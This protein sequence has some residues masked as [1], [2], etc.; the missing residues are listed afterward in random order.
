MSLWRSLLP[1]VC[2][3]HG[4]AVA[5]G[6]DIALCAD[7]VVMAEDARI[8]HPPARVWGLVVNQ[9]YGNM[10]LAATQLLA[11]LCDG[12]ARHTP[13][14]LAWKA[15]AEAVGWKQAVRERDRGEPV[16]RE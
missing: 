7:R 5:G 13:E 12:I 6:S 15:R 16:D 8:G 11:T 1:V 2:K 14:G 3:V 4:Y 9:A 10:G